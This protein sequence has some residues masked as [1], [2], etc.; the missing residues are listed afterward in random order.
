M[1]RRQ[2]WRDAFH[3]SEIMRCTR[4]PL[5]VGSRTNC[6]GSLGAMPDLQSEQYEELL[7][8]R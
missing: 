7:P 4:T 5:I 6:I 8:P 1:P 2:S 3:G